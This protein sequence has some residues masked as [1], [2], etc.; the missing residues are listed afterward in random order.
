MA[1]GRNG[2]NFT[3]MMRHHYN[4]DLMRH[5]EGRWQDIDWE[6]TK[7]HTCEIYRFYQALMK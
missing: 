4:A 5:K 6:K 7:R 2:Y 1:C 3:D